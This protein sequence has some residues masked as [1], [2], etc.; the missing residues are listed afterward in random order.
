MLRS[1]LPGDSTVVTMRLTGAQL[2][3][4]LEQ[5]IEN[6]FAD[7][8]YRRLG[9]IMQVSGIVFVY[10][11]AKQT[12]SRI[13]ELNAGDDAINP[14]REYSVATSSVL[15]DGGHNCLAFRDGR[16]P[17]RH[18]EQFQIIADWIRENKVVRTPADTR[19]SMV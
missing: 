12:G 11:P 9:G 15:A 8:P 4:M 19:I 7:D 5:S 16:D 17:R 10:D 6:M 3:A 14:S 2:R 1:L 18:D 13:V